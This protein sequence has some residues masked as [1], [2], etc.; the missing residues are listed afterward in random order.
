MNY[1]TNINKE[2]SLFFQI[3]IKGFLL[4]SKEEMSDKIINITKTYAT[5]SDEQL[6]IR[7]SYDSYF[8]TLKI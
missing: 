6:N 2:D 7:H 5:K 3:N 8:F 4:S 1:F